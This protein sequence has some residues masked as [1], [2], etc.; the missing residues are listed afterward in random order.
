MHF[1]SQP[2]SEIRV[3][4]APILMANCLVPS[5]LELISDTCR[6]PLIFISNYIRKY[7]A[8][9][10]SILQKCW[11]KYTEVHVQDTRTLRYSF[12]LLGML[13][14][15]YPHGLLPDSTHSSVQM[16]PCQR[17]LPWTPCLKWIHHSPSSTTVFNHGTYPHL[18]FY[19]VF[20]MNWHVCLLYLNESSMRSTVLFTLFTLYPQFPKRLCNAYS[21]FDKWIISFFFFF[22]GC[23]ACGI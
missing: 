21:V 17:E 22:L 8:T 14:D 20:I 10:R 15:K 5:V 6:I 7:N 18:T 2:H 4:M 11:L 3:W 13:L 16:V 19:Y 23:S 9:S 1:P 12:C